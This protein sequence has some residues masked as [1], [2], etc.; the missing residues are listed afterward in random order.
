MLVKAAQI[1]WTY[2]LLGYILKRIANQ[3]CP[4]MALF[5]KEADG[6]AFH[7]E[8][9]VPTIR[10]TPKLNSLIDT[11]TSRKSGNSWKNK[12]FPGGFFKIVGS[13]S[14][15]NVKSTSSVGLAIIEEPDDTN[16]NVKDQ[17]DAIGMLEER[18]K[19][20]PGAKF[21]TGGTPTIKGLSKVEQRFERTEPYV[22]P[23]LCHDCG[24]SHVLDF[25]NVSWLE[26]ES[27]DHPVYGHALPE[28]AV[29]VCPE[30]GSVWDDYRRKEN[31]RNTVFSALE[32]G[33]KLAGWVGGD[34]FSKRI[35]FHEINELYSCLP[36]AGMEELVQ[37]YLTAEHLA[38]QGDEKQKIIFVN[39]KLGRGYEF[40][41]EEADPDKLREV[42]LDYPE[43][44]I[45]KGGLI[46]TAGIDVQHDRLA[47][48][49]RAWGRGEE[50]WLLYWGELI[51]EHT[52]IDKKDAVWKA[53]DQ[54]MFTRI[55]NVQGW[56][57]LI[58]AISIDSGDGSSSDA[59][60][61]W[62]RTRSKSHKKCLIMAVKGSSSQQDP[63]IFT[64]PR[65]VSVD[66]K[67]PDKRTKADRHGVKVYIVGTNKG[68]DFISGQL[69]LEASG[70]G[71]FHFY[72]NVR[73]DYF[74]QVTSEV[75]APHKSVKHRRVWQK[76]AGRRN[77]AFDC[78]DYALHAARAKR[79][80]L[81]KN[82]Q[83]DE[84]ESQL[85]QV[86][87]FSDID[88]QA[89][90]ETHNDKK[91]SASERRAAMAKKLEG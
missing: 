20:Y 5:A 65:S 52:T 66:H 29:Y 64:T 71:R 81:M 38:A 91:Q 63:E 67:R 84:L 15:G 59:V 36:G 12:N 62:V 54:L 3:P 58:S 48:I 61:H 31:I 42:A 51:A 43:F 17:G 13:G 37:S 57:T 33:D 85:S 77:E 35:G 89:E 49:I 39:Q 60:Y 45:P 86:D 26:D 16:D 30:C 22:L 80:H 74:D 8:K 6:K 40:K 53:L 41:G 23:V 19:R 72:K 18:I 11:S 1:G 83:F 34:G 75:K 56:V 10:A 69:M 32:A 21:L 88:K 24:E 82:Y 50:S 87:L 78:E 73:D 27:I 28:T 90:N 68:K 14:P 9:L 79:V 55:K 4:I 76:K 7:D 44:E 46:V 2:F 70:R 47:V 25:N